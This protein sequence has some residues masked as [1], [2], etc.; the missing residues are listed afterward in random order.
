V[1]RSTA[2]MLPCKAGSNVNLP[3]T[4]TTFLA[5]TAPMHQQIYV[6]LGTSSTTFSCFPLWVLRFPVV[7]NFAALHSADHTGSILPDAEWIAAVLLR[8]DVIQ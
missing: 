8:T 6:G 1:Y 7:N 2:E 5:V 4:V 3:S